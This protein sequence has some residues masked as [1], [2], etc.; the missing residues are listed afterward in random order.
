MHPSNAKNVGNMKM[1]AVEHI[2]TAASGLSVESRLNRLF[3]GALGA[4]RSWNDA[5]LT[6][7]ALARLS[8]RELA[9]IGL[10]R[11]EIGEVVASLRG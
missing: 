3:A 9:D 2:R 5:R 1:A 7:N 4:Y 11:A 8:D 10:S 6:R